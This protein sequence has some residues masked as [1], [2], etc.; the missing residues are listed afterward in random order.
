[1][2][3]PSDHYIQN[4]KSYL[5]SLLAGFNAINSSEIITLGVKPSFVS[6]AYGY[7]EVDNRSMNHDIQSVTKFIEKPCDKVAAEL[8]KKKNIFWNA[9]SFITRADTLYQAIERFRPDILQFAK[10]S[11]ECA[12]VNDQSILLNE[13]AFD[14]CPSESIDYAVLENYTNLKLAKLNTKWSDVGSWNSLANLFESDTYNNRTNSNQGQFFF[15]Q[16]IL[17][18]TPQ[19]HDPW[20]PLV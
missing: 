11:F 1:M 13:E 7:I 5:R 14:S 16:K 20:L 18:Y 12:E 10:K 6:T 9:G 15:D 2:F 17:L 8:V 3:C 19:H 4:T